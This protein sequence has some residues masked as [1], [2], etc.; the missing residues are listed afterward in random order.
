MTTGGIPPLMGCMNVSA[1]DAE[2]YQKAVKA[3]TK[4]I[5]AYAKRKDMSPKY[6]SKLLFSDGR[7][8]AALEGGGTLH[9]E[10]FKEVLSE[11]EALENGLQAESA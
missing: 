3:L 11:L 8:L 10:T 2:H 4:R 9:P 1:S 5:R 6:V 7:R